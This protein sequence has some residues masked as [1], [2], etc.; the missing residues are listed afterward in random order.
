[1]THGCASAQVQRL[2][3]DNLIMAAALAS[4]E[5]QVE[6]G[7]AASGNQING[8]HSFDLFGAAQVCNPI[9]AAC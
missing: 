3:H 9:L 1:M 8:P 4:Y 2:L 6:N 5:T 7:Y